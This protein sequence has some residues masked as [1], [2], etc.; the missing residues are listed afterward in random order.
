MLFD[1]T[2]RGGVEAIALGVITYIGGVLT[3]PLSDYIN[4]R[5]LRHQLKIALYGETAA[6]YSNLV[7]LSEGG[8]HD[9]I[10]ALVRMEAYKAAMA[11]PTVYYAIKEKHFFDDLYCLA[12]GYGR[13]D[14]RALDAKLIVTFID[15]QVERQRLNR[16]I[17]R[18]HC[19]SLG[20]EHL[21]KVPKRLAI[22]RDLKELKKSLNNRQ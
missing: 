6:L 14:T 18:K 5:V 4:H 13:N 15:E 17:L 10:R 8:N 16:R 2:M 21:D 9:D 11:G 22:E 1:L 12:L 3:K 7:L 19:N 20:K